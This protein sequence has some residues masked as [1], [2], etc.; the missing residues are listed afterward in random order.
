MTTFASSQ[1][2]NCSFWSHLPDPRE[3]YAPR[4][5]GPARHLGSVN[6]SGFE[7]RFASWDHHLLLFIVSIKLDNNPVTHIELLVSMMSGT[8]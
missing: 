1:A 4:E 6:A 7:P 2:K 8:F 3:D 5:L